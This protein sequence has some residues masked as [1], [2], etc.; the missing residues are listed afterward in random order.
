MSFWDDFNDSASQL[1]DK[2]ISGN[3]TTEELVQDSDCLSLMRDDNPHIIEFLKQPDV[4]RRL[5]Q[6]SLYPEIKDIPYKDQ[7]TLAHRANEVLTFRLDSFQ[8][9]IIDDEDSLRTIFDYINRRENEPQTHLVVSFFAKIIQTLY[10][11]NA[12]K[13][14]EYMK[15]HEF[16]QTLVSQLRYSALSELLNNLMFNSPP[17]SHEDF[18]DL[19]ISSNFGLLLLNE[20]ISTNDPAAARNISN[21]WNDIVKSLREGVYNLSVGEDV[22]LNQLTAPNVVS[23]LLVTVLDENSSINTVIHMLDVLIVLTERDYD[24]GLPSI[25]LNQQTVDDRL[26][27]SQTEQDFVVEEVVAPFLGKIL[28]LVQRFVVVEDA[29][30]IVVSVLRLAENLLNTS[31]PARRH[32]LRDG[33]IEGNFHEIFALVQAVPTWSIVTHSVS[34]MTGYLLHAAPS[35]N[36]A[37]VEFVFAEDGLNLLALILIALDEFLT[38]EVKHDEDLL[39][40]FAARTFWFRLAERIET[41][42]EHC[43][44]AEAVRKA[45]AA[46]PEALHW[47][48]FVS[49][50]LKP[51]IS[52]NREDQDDNNTTL[53]SLPC[54]L[55]VDEVEIELSSDNTKTSFYDDKNNGNPTIEVCTPTGS[56]PDVSPKINDLSLGEKTA[57]PQVVHD[58]D[59]EDAVF[60][61][62]IA[63]IADTITSEAKVDTEQSAKPPPSE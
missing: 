40:V 26:R 55:S 10:N 25:D 5:I 17:T 45:I 48:K 59:I 2:I 29:S 1:A 38:P 11:V 60:D 6:L 23:K 3:I 57:A 13:I 63:S 53:S 44:N 14:V 34:M 4:Y 12:E 56:E 16:L 22:L 30:D 35:E 43:R 47:S 39:N 21:V 62:E 54:N 58:A 32:V 51:Y 7:Y 27:I 36:N 20:L 42:T 41:A 52:A 8:A 9:A 31:S 15:D 24:L 46:S 33:L 61:A 19:L 49:E 18:R 28:L 37:L 50:H